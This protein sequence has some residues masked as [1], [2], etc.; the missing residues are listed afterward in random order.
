MKFL[1]CLVGL[2]AVNALNVDKIPE[3]NVLLSVNINKDKES[4]DKQDDGH[5][6]GSGS[7]DDSEEI[8][9]VVLA[10]VK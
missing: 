4:Q 8:A 7:D 6:S 3:H 5:D 1:L 9:K 10:I 2:V